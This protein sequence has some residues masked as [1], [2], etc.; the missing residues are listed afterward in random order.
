MMY[1]KAD[2]FAYG[3]HVLFYVDIPGI[4]AVLRRIINKIRIAAIHITI[5]IVKNECSRSGKLCAVRQDIIAGPDATRT[6]IGYGLYRNSYIG[7]Q[8]DGGITKSIRP[9]ALE[10]VPP[11]APMVFVTG[12]PIGVPTAV[13]AIE[14][15][16]LV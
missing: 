2:G 3:V 14:V 8:G 11:A 13:I 12:L 1:V 10:T 5:C 6:F 15:S 4:G 9:S 16:L 7:G